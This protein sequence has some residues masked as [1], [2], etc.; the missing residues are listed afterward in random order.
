MRIAATMPEPEPPSQSVDRDP[1]DERQLLIDIGYGDRAAADELVERTYEMV[2]GAL[3]RL[4]GGDA[5]LAADLTQ[6]SYRRAWSS[7][8]GFEGRS[9]FSTWVYRIAYTTFLNHIRRPHRVVPMEE[10]H[11]R[12]AEDPAVSSESL[13]MTNQ[14]AERLRRAVLEL[15][16][17][18]REVVT[19][20]YWGEI[21]VREIARSIGLSEQGTRKRLKKALTI[22]DNA[23]E[24]S[25]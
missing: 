17:P 18:L 3:H 19:A 21:P 1:R 5:D 4:T 20:R 11:L 8:A 6:E 2:Y 22:L 24:V 23:L 16:E 12:T 14:Q 9:R 13:A 25:S 15:P 7:L 10:G